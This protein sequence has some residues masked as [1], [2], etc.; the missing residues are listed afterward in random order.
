MPSVCRRLSGQVAHP[1]AA[2]VGDLAEGLRALPGPRRPRGVR[3]PFVSVLL[4]ACSAVVARAR[5]FVAIGQWAASAPQDTLARLGARVTTVFA[6]RP[7]R[8]VRRSGAY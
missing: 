1:L 7:R 2:G 6:S 3:H 8:A 5:S 4:V